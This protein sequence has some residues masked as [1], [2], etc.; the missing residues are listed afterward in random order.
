MFS[1]NAGPDDRREEQ[2]FVLRVI[3]QLIHAL[4]RIAK[5]KDSGLAD[6]AL[7]EI[8]ESYRE[9]FDLDPFLAR[10]LDGPAL[11]RFA[12]GRGLRRELAALL[13]VESQTLA[14]RGQVA[15][16]ARLGEKADYLL[17]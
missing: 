9:L 2:D 6:E 12:E 10:F 7:A 16:A 5:L 1:T 14:G 11:A 4:A 8:H 15:E 13:Q 3:N 17:G